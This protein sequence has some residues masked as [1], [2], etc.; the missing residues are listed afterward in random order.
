MNKK[1][2][3]K[4]FFERINERNLMTLFIRTLFDYKN[5]HD[6]NYLFRLKEEKNKIII[7][8]YD[9]VSSNRFNRYIFIFS[10]GKYDIKIIEE[11]NVFVNYIYILNISNPQSNLLKFAYLFNIDEDMMIKY[12]SSF[13]PDSI[14]EILIEILEKP[15]CK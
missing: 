7:D 3:M 13:L 1:G 8:V 9:N 5:L 4:L 2:I 10:V 11:S 12:A 15:I 6:Y 14:V